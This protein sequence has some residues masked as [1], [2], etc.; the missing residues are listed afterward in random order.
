MAD[1][2]YLRCDEYGEAFW[3]LPE[4]IRMSTGRNKPC[5]LGAGFYEKFTD[6]IFPSDDCPV[7]GKGIIRK[8]PRYYQNILKTEDPATLE[9]VKELRQQFKKAHAADYTPERLLDKYK[10]MQARQTKRNL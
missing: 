2:H 3:L 5:G 10:I 4:Y 9:L 1:E 6:D 7:P 8:V